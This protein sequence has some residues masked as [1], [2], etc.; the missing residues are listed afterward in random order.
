VKEKEPLRQGGDPPEGQIVPA[1][2]HQLVAYRHT[3]VLLAKRRGKDDDRPEDAATSGA[4]ISSDVRTSGLP[5]TPTACAT[6]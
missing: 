1:H 2:V 3:T 5:R 4:A 6:N